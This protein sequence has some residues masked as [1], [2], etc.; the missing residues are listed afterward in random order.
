MTVNKVPFYTKEKTCSGSL[1]NGPEQFVLTVY[2]DNN[3]V[4][5]MIE[6][7]LSPRNLHTVYTADLEY[8]GTF[9]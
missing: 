9:A 4:R 2:T 7:T 6:K 1:K 3:Q 8:E 5:I